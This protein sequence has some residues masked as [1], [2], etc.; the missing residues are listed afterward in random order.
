[1]RSAREPLGQKASSGRQQRHQYERP[2]PQP[3]VLAAASVLDHRPAGQPR[4]EA[5]LEHYGTSITSVILVVN[6]Q[7]PR[8]S[9]ARSGSDWDIT[10]DGTDLGP[11]SLLTSDNGVTETNGTYSITFDTGW[12]YCGYYNTAT[13]YTVEGVNAIG[14]G[15]SSDT[16]HIDMEYPC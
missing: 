14:E 1:L 12:D 2:P 3:P 8:S 15:V 10:Q 9:P 16:V 4:A 5:G 6:A 7:A 11:A 13:P